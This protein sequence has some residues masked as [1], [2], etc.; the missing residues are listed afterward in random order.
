MVKSFK[1]SIVAAFLGISVLTGCQLSEAVA[2]VDHKEI[3]KN[4]VEV[5]IPSVK[6]GASSDVLKKINAEL[7]KAVKDRL[8]EYM[9][10]LKED[11][12]V[13]TD[14]YIFYSSYAVKFNKNDLVSMVMDSY[15]YTGGAHGMKWKDSVTADL[16]TGKILKLGDLFKFG[17]AYDTVLNEK[18]RAQID[19]KEYRKDDI[20]FVGV[21]NETNFYLTEELLVIYYQPYDIAPYVYGMVAFYIDNDELEDIYKDD[22]NIML[23]KP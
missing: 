18:I 1:K 2:L 10:Y 22:I 9:G 11:T 15:Q 16:K 20:S 13:S 12:R 14:R 17:S 23:Q 6:K 7:D 19:A 4:N 21:N 5:L 3:K 8:D